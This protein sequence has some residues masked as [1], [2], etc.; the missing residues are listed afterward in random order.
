MVKPSHPPAAT[1]S[2]DRAGH[3]FRANDALKDEAEW[4]AHLNCY[5]ALFDL[6][7]L[8]LAPAKQWRG[9]RPRKIPRFLRLRARTPRRIETGPLVTVI[10]PFWNA[11]STLEFAVR[12]VLNQ[13]WRPLELILIDDASDDASPQIAKRLA[14]EDSRMH[15]L[16]N[17]V[18]VGPYV[19]RNRAL[20]IARGEFITGQDADEW[21]HPERIERQTAFMLADRSLKASHDMMLRMKQ[22]GRVALF[23]QKDAATDDRIL[24]KAWAGCFY[25][26]QFMNESL[27][28]FDSLR[29]GADGEFLARARR[30]LGDGF[31]VNRRLG[32]LSLDDPQSLSRDPVHGISRETGLSPVRLEYRDAYRAWHATLSP[33]AGDMCLPFPHHPR[34]FPAPEAIVVPLEKVRAVIQAK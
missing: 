11:A 23:G 24:Q 21:A 32:I 3:L 19:S 14:R 29:F 12:S 6:E 4:L 26:R 25:E 5:V 16:R 18:N 9:F 20:Q 15:L 10:M 31:A 22:N 7:T 8:D 13:S 27:G 1:S 30:L 34:R 2:S 17:S 33:H 28:Y